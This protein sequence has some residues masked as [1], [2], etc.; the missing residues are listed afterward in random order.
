MQYHIGQFRRPQLDS[1]S[2]PLSITIRPGTD[3]YADS[4]GNFDMNFIDVFGDL[5]GE[6]NILNNKNSYYLQF[7]VKQRSDSVQKFALKLR[8]R[9]NNFDSKNDQQLIEEYTVPR[10]TGIKYFEVIL[11]PFTT[12]DQILWQLKRTTDEISIIDPQ[13]GIHGRVMEIIQDDLI[14]TKLTDL[15]PILRSKASNMGNLKKIGIQGP[16]SLLM[17]I[18]REPIR[19]GRSGIYEINNGIEITSI[20]FVPKQI[21]QSGSSSGVVGAGIVESAQVGNS[22]GVKRRLDYF[23]MDYEY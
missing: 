14:F 19:I 16:P 9:N 15:L 10:G 1:Y 23:I 11:S 17:C 7:G 13:T 8:N 3:E 4:S 6:D 18:N 5:E 21:I 12:Y 20:S 2:T 22:E